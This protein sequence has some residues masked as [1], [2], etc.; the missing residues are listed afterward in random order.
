MRGER[1]KRTPLLYGLTIKDAIK[2]GGYYD[3]NNNWNALITFPDK[4][5]LVFRD[6]VEVLILN[7]HNDIYMVNYKNGTY[8]LPGGGVEKG[9]GYKYQVE[10][11][12]KEE[13]GIIL[14]RI[15]NVNVS[16]FRYFSNEYSTCLIHWNGTYSRVYVAHFKDWYYGKV[17]SSLIDTEMMQKGRFV[18][19]KQAI[20]IL[21]ED[22]RIAISNYFK[23]VNK[24]E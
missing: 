22:H 6:R 19:Y 10:Q 21:S 17:K 13:A 7:K 5:N 15:Y 1:E 18:P 12:S 24:K 8:R 11:E 14:G 9:R 2:D 4:P 20:K 23:T 16:Y 3:I